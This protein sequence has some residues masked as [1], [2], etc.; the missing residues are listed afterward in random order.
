[1]IDKINSE[2]PGHILTI[3]DPVEFAHEHKRSL[4]NQREVGQDTISITRALKS[5]LRQDPDIVLIGEMRDLET[6]S[7]A[8]TIAETGHLVFATL[9][10]N[11]TSSTITRIIDVFPAHQQPQ[12]RNQLS[13]SLQGI[14]CQQLLPSLDG[15]RVMAAEIMIPNSAIRAQI[16]EDKIHQLYQSMQLGSDKSGM[17]TMTQALISLL[18]RRK[19]TIETALMAATDLDDLKAN[20]GRLGLG[21]F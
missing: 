18:Q 15:G 20:L 16:R 13:A 19:I 2:V 5:A 3:E 14:L 1:M 11:S 4:I 6:M 12:V 10:T 17:Q 21:K 9:H 7:A 8:L